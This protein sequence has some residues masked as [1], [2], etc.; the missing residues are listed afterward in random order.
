[1]LLGN[2]LLGLALA[3]IVWIIA[4]SLT[5]STKKDLEAIR[6]YAADKGWVVLYLER[7]YSGRYEPA[8]Y[9]LRY[10]DRDDVVYEALLERDFTAPIQI[11]RTIQLPKDKARAM[12]DLTAEM[13]CR[14][15]GT[16]IPRHSERCPY[17]NAARDFFPA[18]YS[19]KLRIAGYG[20]P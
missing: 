15:C 14:K 16:T 2:I 8:R 6:R 1:M 13:D 5:V 7:G 4:L 3:G 10:R 20:E 17:C 11:N 9:N 18:I 12:T 19:G